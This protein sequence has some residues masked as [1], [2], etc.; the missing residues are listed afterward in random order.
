MLIEC[1]NCIAI[2]GP[3]CRSAFQRS[4]RHCLKSSNLEVLSGL[5]K[6]IFRVLGSKLGH[7][8]Y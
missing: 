5:Q 2:K 8:S 1:N 6:I 3:I 4:N 7:C